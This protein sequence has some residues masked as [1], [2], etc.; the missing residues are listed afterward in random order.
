MA[1]YL[2]GHITVTD[3]ERWGQY[4]AG[5]ADSLAGVD[6]T[7]IFRG[8]LASVLAGEHEYERVVV[9]QFADLQTLNNWF[10]SESYQKLIPLRDSAANVTITTYEA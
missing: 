7:I 8:M 6:S 2:V 10:Q 1:A 3:E 9:I 5:V 4:V